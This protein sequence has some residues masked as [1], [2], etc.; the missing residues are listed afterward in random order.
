MKKVIILLISIFILSGCYNYLELNDLAIVDALGIDYENGTYTVTAQV[1]SVQ[2][3]G[4]E[5]TQEQAIV[6]I[7][8]GKSIPEAVRNMELKNPNYIYMG[9][10]SLVVLGKDFVKN[11][12]NKI[13]EYILR[14]PQI[15]INTLVVA[16]IKNTALEILNQQVESGSLPSEAIISSLETGE[17]FQGTT[18]QQT[19]EELVKNSLSSAESVLPTIEIEENKDAGKETISKFNKIKLGNL[20]VIKDKKINY[21]MNEDESLIYNLLKKN[22]DNIRINIPYKNEQSVIEIYGPSPKIDLK[23]KDN[24]IKVDIKLGLEGDIVELNQEEN[25][26]KNSVIN[27]LNKNMNKKLKNYLNQLLESCKK[28]NIDVLGLKEIIYK[29]YNKEYDKY[30]NKNIYEEAHINIKIDSNIYKEGGI[31]EGIN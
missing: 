20:A 4:S 2:K 26:K 16:S 10:L 24:Q 22:I 17:K 15:R 21:I 23:I 29:N 7:A 14:Y 25:V 8:E 9:H 18:K 31:Y 19:L 13:Y 6:Y 28:E 12:I 3:S 27:E 30:K 5:E 1:I 11:D